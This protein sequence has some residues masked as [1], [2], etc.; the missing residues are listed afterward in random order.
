MYLECDGT[1]R[2]I[3]ESG[4]LRQRSKG[5][6]VYTFLLLSSI[7]FISRIA[8]EW[9]LVTRETVAAEESL[10]SV[11]SEQRA[12]TEEPMVPEDRLTP[13]AC[14]VPTAS[15]ASTLASGRKETSVVWVGGA[16]GYSNQILSML[17][18]YRRIQPRML[19]MA[20]MRTEHAYPG[21][22][23]PQCLGD[24]L[25][26]ENTAC[27][28]PSAST[29]ED[30]RDQ[31]VK[32]MNCSFD[33]RENGAL[34]GEGTGDHYLYWRLRS[35]E[36]WKQLPKISFRN[37]SRTLNC[38]LSKSWSG[39]SWDLWPSRLTIKAEYVKL[40]QKMRQSYFGSAPYLAV[41][42]RRGD[43]LTTKCRAKLDTSANCGSALDLH[44]LI[45]RKLRG[46]P[47]HVYV[48]TN[49]KDNATLAQLQGFGYKLQIDAG[50]D[51]NSL[52]SF[53]A[54][55][56]LL[57]CASEV[58]LPGFSFHAPKTS[59]Q[60]LI[61]RFRKY[62]ASR[63][64]VCGESLRVLDAVSCGTFVAESCEACPVDECHGA[65]KWNEDARTCHRSARTNFSKREPRTGQKV[66]APSALDPKLNPEARKPQSHKPSLNSP[67]PGRV[68]G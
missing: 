63:S 3:N 57:G 16:E 1:V 49:E 37:S 64:D 32:S 39:E 30:D 44:Y 41:H 46:R 35:M 18:V 20:P 9:A 34:R 5:Y 40:F 12:V 23:P 45:N 54:D 13:T 26:L 24:V 17:D 4:S 42:W 48:A 11:S 38:V 15:R 8:L 36:T 51:F 19:V 25:E 68:Q 7:A 10:P 33:T 29:P 14:N 59:V 28:S 58:L 52:E 55:V 56:F 22:N 31:I 47:W 67:K 21:L 6:P 43:Q 50:C 27:L 66:R 53:F 60:D 62:H 2:H 65:C 61:H